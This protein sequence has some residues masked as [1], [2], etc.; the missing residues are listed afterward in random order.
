MRSL[1]VLSFAL[2]LFATSLRAQDWGTPVWSDEF[3]RPAG[4]ALDPAKWT[5]DIGNLGVNDEVEIYCPGFPSDR[6]Q[7]KPQHD[8]AWK[9]IAACREKDGNVS[10]D[11]EHLVLRA[12]QHNDVWTSGRIK[13]EGRQTFQYGRIEARIKLPFGPGLWPAF[14]ALGE[15]IGKVGWPSSGE[16]D[17]MENVPE[18]G[19][20]G[21]AR[22]RS[23]IHGPGY[24]GDFGVRNDL[25]FPGGGRVDTEFHVYG[26]IWSPY[27]MQFYVDDPKNVFFV[28]TPRELPAGREW[29]YNQPFFL[30]LNLAV[31]SRKSWS[32]ATNASTPNPADML[33]DYVR[34]YK[35]KPIAGPK[36]EAAPI[37][38][39]SGAAA[40]FPVKLSAERGSGRMY[41]A[42]LTVAPGLSCSLQGD[43]VDFTAQAEATV[44]I[45]VTSQGSPPEKAEIVLT[46]YTVSGEKSSVRIPVTIH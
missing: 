41:L 4:S 37:T 28:V 3:N 38:L 36:F 33:V 7:A 26:V 32:G 23:T 10:F 17:V 6:D 1:R 39:R 30:I 45:V 14:W 19:G 22:I 43:V 15:N 2:L 44:P 46:A 8:S 11:G 20:L 31:G 42:C 34:V 5:F 18:V 12:T 29:V 13:T 24:S 16:I 25:E 40:Q 35:A 27:M 21:P 9:E